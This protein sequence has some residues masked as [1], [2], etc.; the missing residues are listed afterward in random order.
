MN[1]YYSNL[2]EGHDTRPADIERAMAGD[3]DSDYQTRNLQLEARAHLR[4][5]KS[6][7]ELAAGGRLP[8][9]TSALFVKE[10]HRAF[11]EGADETMLTI[12]GNGRQFIMTPGVWRSAPEH[13]VAVGRHQPPTSEHVA[14]FM[15]YFETR[16]VLDGLGTAARI[17]A[18]PAAHHRLNYIHP[19]PDGNGRVSRLMSHAM[20][21][22]AGIA[23]HGLW[24]IS[25]GLARGI[26]GRGDYKRMMDATDAPRRNDFDGRGNLS[27]ASLEEFTEWFLQVC[28]DQV[29]FMGTLF[30]LS[31]LADRI[32]AAVA[33]ERDLAPEAATL[34][35]QVL[36]RGEMGR[37][38]VADSV[39]RSGRSTSRLIS[40]LVDRG[41]L[42][43]NTVKGPVALGFPIKSLGVLFPALF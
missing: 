26:E 3:L 34:L 24:S 35:V 29:R 36:V 21:W 4:V 6:I 25:R 18:I 15:D 42:H 41:F 2:I 23:A 17:L 12:R 28:L 40:Q 37:G 43:S 8:N 33:L 30:D 5:Q 16:Y 31:G 27:L 38:A 39:G 11:Y 22:S 7:D 13:D 14:G 32:K 9:P 19:F 20:G 10:L 1:T